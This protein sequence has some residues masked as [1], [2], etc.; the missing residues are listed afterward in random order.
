LEDNIRVR[1]FNKCFKFFGGNPLI[2]GAADDSGAW[3]GYWN[4]PTIWSD[5]ALWNRQMQV[6]LELIEPFV[7]FG[8]AD[9]VLDF[10]CG[11]G[12]FAMQM[13]GRVK[14]I[15]C[16][17]LS[18][19]SVELCQQKFASRRDVSVVKLTGDLAQLAALGPG[20]TKTLCLSV[21]QYFPSLHYLDEF[22]VAV[23]KISVRGGQLILVDVGRAERTWREQ[24]LTVLF[25]LRHGMFWQVVAKL[26]Q[27]Q[28]S[29][30][31][32]QA[33]LGRA[34][35]LEIP[36]TYF[37]SAQQRLRVKVSEIPRQLTLNANRKSYI[38][39]FV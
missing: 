10:G 15:V 17:D 38:I 9:R 29:D 35:H 1:I 30:D 27:V 13:Q 28:F 7:K 20:C 5:S 12:I 22:I 2:S 37:E 18:Q 8:A 36:E 33:V 14:E 19:H 6:L 31:A 3:A 23:G 4:A 26:A 16:A 39:E 11:S 21:I 32:Y 25:T 34:G 24:L